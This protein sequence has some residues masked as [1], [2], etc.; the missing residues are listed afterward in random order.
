MYGFIL[1][2]PL[3]SAA[4]AGLFGRHLGE[5]GA[6]ILTTSCISLTFGLSMFILYE[7]GFCGSNTY[8]YL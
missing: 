4:A 1:V 2:I 5:R 8:L 7:V 6:G 3:F